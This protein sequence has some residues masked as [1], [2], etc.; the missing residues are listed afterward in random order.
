M[1]IIL[2]SSTLILLAKLDLLREL[3]GEFCASMPRRVRQEALAK[4]SPDAE[5]IRLLVR[6]KRLQVILAP[7]EMAKK[8][9]KDFRLY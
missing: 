9:A 8:L 2:Y 5:L 1:Q 7:R 4:Q 6:E 3:T